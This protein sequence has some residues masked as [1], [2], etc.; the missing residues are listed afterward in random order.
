MTTTRRSTPSVA[1]RQV[2]WISIAGMCLCAWGAIIAVDSPL[3][4]GPLDCESPNLPSPPGLLWLMWL[5]M[6]S[7]AS[8]AVVVH[9][10]RCNGNRTSAMLAGLG[11]VS[12]LLTFPGFLAMGAGMSCGL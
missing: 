1:V 2:V 3:W 12:A 9:R 7:L 5:V 6:A 10:Q 8:T 4:S 11:V